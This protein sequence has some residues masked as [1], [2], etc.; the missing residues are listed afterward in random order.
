MDSVS[1]TVAGPGF[2]PE[3]TD[4][5]L[6][7]RLPLRMGCR[8]S[9]VKRDGNRTLP[10]WSANVSP[11]NPQKTKEPTSG[12]EPLTCS[13]RVRSHMFTGVSVYFRDRLR[14]LCLPIRR[15]S[16]CVHIRAGYCHGYSQVTRVRSPP[17]IGS[18]RHL[19]TLVPVDFHTD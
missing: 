1:P 3:L 5:K 9:V 17:I 10:Y 4:P 11:A 15:F 14:K 16:L 6:E 2:E 13:L 19:G 18:E 8:Q 7:K 12:L